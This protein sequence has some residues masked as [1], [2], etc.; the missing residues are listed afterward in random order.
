MAEGWRW[1]TYVVAVVMVLVVLPEG[2]LVLA[3]KGG[4]HRNAYVAMMYM[5][6]PRDYEFYVA[7]RVMMRSLAR[8]KVE[9]DLI[10]ISSIDVPAR[11]TNAL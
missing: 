9:A 7:T 3:E 1:K 2:R 4:G 5:G 6:T 11:W 10:V 8:L